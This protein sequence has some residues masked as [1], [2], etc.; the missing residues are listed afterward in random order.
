MLAPPPE[1][2]EPTECSGE[3]ADYEDQARDEDCAQAWQNEVDLVAL[4]AGAVQDASPLVADPPLPPKGFVVSV[5]K[6][7][8]FRRLHLVPDCRLIPGV[9][10]KVFDVWGDQLPDEQDLNAVCDLCLPNGRPDLEQ[11]LEEALLGSPSSSSSGD[12]GAASEEA[13]GVGPVCP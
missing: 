13:A 11:P 3:D 12:E 10:Y 5:T 9:H 1:P 7:S 4:T 6:R 2:Y 8:K